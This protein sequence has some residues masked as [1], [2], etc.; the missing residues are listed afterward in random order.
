MATKKSSSTTKPADRI[1]VVITTSRRGVFFGEID[2]A[3]VMNPV[4]EVFHK[5]NC[6]RWTGGLKGFIDLAVSGPSTQSRVGPAAPQA[7]VRD[8][9]D[10]LLCTPEAAARW[11]AAPWG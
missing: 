3:T 7:W 1:K 9:T 11:E 4:I 2:P 6:L 8:I 10:V 5:R